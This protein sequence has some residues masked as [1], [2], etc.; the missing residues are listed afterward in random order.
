MQR[1]AFLLLFVVSI[2]FAYRGEAALTETKHRLD[3]AAKAGVVN[4]QQA[5][6]G[7]NLAQRVQAQCVQGG[8]VAEKLG[9][10]CPAASSV[11]AASPTPVPGPNGT[12]IPGP[13]GAPGVAGAAITGAAGVSGSN[14]PRGIA[15]PPGAS[16]KPGVAGQGGQPGQGG[17]SGQVGGEGRAGNPGAAGPSGAAGD[18]GPAGPSGASGPPGQP[19]FS[20]TILG[21]TCSRDTPFDPAQPT[22][23]CAP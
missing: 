15:G 21:M 8:A 7:Q 10:L 6:A 4:G 22:Y 9:K 18:P 16:G 11:A 14:G 19:P 12:V 23:T 1:A 13:R 3:G 17:A 2:Y 20:F 5:A